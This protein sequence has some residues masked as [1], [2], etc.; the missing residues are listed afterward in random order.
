MQVLG[1]DIAKRSFRAALIRGA[2]FKEKSFDNSEKGFQA[3]AA[4]LQKWADGPVHACL[5]ATGNYG[6]DLACF[7]YNHQH[8][9]SIVNP[10]K[11]KGYAHSLTLRTKTDS[12]DAKLIARYCQSH[13]PIAWVPP[14]L[15]V[16]ELQA[17]VR[18]LDALQ[19][20]RTQ[21]LNRLDETATPTVHDDVQAHIQYLDQDIEQLRQRIRDHIDQDPDLKNQDELL[22]TI[23]GIS[24]NTSAWLLA[25]IRFDRYQHAR[26]VAAHAGLVPQHHQSGDTINGKSRLS[27]IGNARLRKALYF[28]AITAIRFN[29]I[30]QVFAER[31]RKANKSK[32]TV[33]AAVMRKLI[34]IAFGVL[35]SGQPFNPK[36]A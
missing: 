30:I 20:M 6:E 13:T 12:L 17:L 18:R 16:R 1:I 27:K 23:P 29:P 19:A 3:L 8:V 14:P 7:L 35:R 15:A 10:M 22:Q 25:E 9:V 24:N 33:I 21:E 26:Q 2:K 34:H 5:E 4:W 31:L 32:M 36:L 11:I 28:P